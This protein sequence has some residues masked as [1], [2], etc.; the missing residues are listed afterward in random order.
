[1]FRKKA[2]YLLIV[3]SLLKKTKDIGQTKTE[4]LIIVMNRDKCL[5]CFIIDIIHCT[6]HCT[7]YTV[8]SIAGRGRRHDVG[9]GSGTGRVGVL[10][11]PHPTSGFLYSKF[12]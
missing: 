9:Y 3:S 6:E 8:Q 10:K 5:S 7:L 4:I 1:M 11:T 2:A 12:R